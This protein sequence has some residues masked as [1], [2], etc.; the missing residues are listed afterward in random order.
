MSLWGN[1]DNIESAGTVS[2]NYETL[3][4]DG[5]GTT[6]TNF[7]VGQVVRFG[8]RSGDYYGDAVISGI[9][10]DTVLSIAST[11]GLSGAAIASTDFYVSELPVY[12]IGDSTYSESASGTN[13]KI[14]YGISTSSVSDY[15]TSGLALNYH[16]AH[17]GWVGIL[18]YTDNHG[19]LRV[20]SEVLVAASGIQTGANGIEYPTP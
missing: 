7:E 10:S 20:K 14:V 9:T 6:F 12:T 19:N 8:D 2:L 15:G 4:V 5:S 11:S 18:T 3:Q 13:D 16:V 1:N 17:H